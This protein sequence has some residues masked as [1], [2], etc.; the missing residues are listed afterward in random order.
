LC[1]DAGI[2]KIFSGYDE[3]TKGFG[4]MLALCFMMYFMGF[5]NGTKIGVIGALQPREALM[6][7]NV[8]Y[9]EIA[10]TV[11]CNSD[12]CIEFPISMIQ[13]SAQGKEHSGN[14]ENQEEEVVSFKEGIAFFHVMGFMQAPKKAMHDEFVREPSYKFHY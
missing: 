7:E 2:T 10:E 1:L 6:N 11:E 9:Q 8:M 14:G 13:G 4:S 5:A 12:S 3:H